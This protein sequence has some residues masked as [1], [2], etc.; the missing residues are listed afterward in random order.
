M[1]DFLVAKVT[2]S[3]LF[4]IKSKGEKFACLTAYDAT[5]SHL[6]SQCGIEVILVGDSLGNVIQGHKTTLQVTVE[7]MAYHTAC[8][9]KVEPQ[10]LVITDLPFMSYPHS[11]EAIKTAATMMR[12]GA[13]MVKVEGGQ[14][15]SS[16]IFD[17]V[18]RGIP[19]CGHLGLTPQSFHMLGGYKVQGRNEAE[20]ATILSDA[21]S[22]QEAGASLLVLECVP[23]TLASEISAKLKIPVIGIGAGPNTDGQV[24]VLHDML[25]LTTNSPSFSKDFLRDTDSVTTAIKTFLN[26]VKNREFPEEDNWYS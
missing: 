7:S 23:E 3:D 17:L 20:A 26:S 2:I 1:D 25:G 5:F 15:L 6:I 19:V 24:L 9:T 22:I 16:I 11:D 10:S 12:S 21:L 18:E 13:E 4:K 8:V 14:W